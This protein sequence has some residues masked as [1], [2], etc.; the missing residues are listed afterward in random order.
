MIPFQLFHESDV[1]IAGE[2]RA[3]LRD[4]LLQVRAM[5]ASHKNTVTYP[6]GCH[7]GICAAADKLDRAEVHVSRINLFT[8]DEQLRQYEAWQND[9]IRVFEAADLPL[10]DIVE[11]ENRYCGDSCCPHK[12]AAT[13]TTR[14]GVIE[15]WWRK[16]V[17]V[18]KWEGV[19]FKA[20]ASA[21]FPAAT[22]T[23]GEYDIHC[24]DYETAIERLKAIRKVADYLALEKAPPL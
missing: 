9:V 21:L 5:A 8:T 22:D 1:K 17:C 10:L 3:A 20:T 14:I 2:Q 19:E 12:P 6:K 16:R 7:C 18:L 24:W 4:A 13:V 15:F 11:S 23:V